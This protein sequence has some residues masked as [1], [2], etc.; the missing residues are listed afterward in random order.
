[1][2][3]DPYGDFARLA[4]YA[5]N[6][7]FKTEVQ[8]QGQKKQDADLGKLVNILKE[9]RYRGYVALEYEAAA[10]PMQAIPGHLRK[11]KELF[12]G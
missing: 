10:E 2:T 6:V 8:Y 12:A 3:A 1:R 11:L 7:Q 5:V 9:A 4:P